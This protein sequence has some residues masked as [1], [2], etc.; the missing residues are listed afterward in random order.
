MI[1]AKVVCGAALFASTAAGAAAPAS[2]PL[3]K[4]ALPGSSQVHG[5][6]RASSSLRVEYT[7]FSKLYG[8]RAVVT[9]NSRFGLGQATR[10]TVSLSQ[11]Q[12][13][14]AGTAARG[15]EGA[16][17]IDR[18]WSDRLSTQTSASVASNGA[19]FAKRLISQNVSYKLA[20]RLVGV[21]GA[22]YSSYGN[23][24]DVT[25][26]SAGAAYYMRGATLSYRYSLLAS[27]RFGRSSGHLASVRLNDPHG[28][29]STQLWAGHGTSLYEANL[30]RTPNGRFTSFAA[31]RS[32]PIGGGIVLQA[33]VN[34]A[35]YKTAAGS[36]SGTGLVAGLSFSNWR[37]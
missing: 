25:T 31:Q 24:S 21:F 19:I 20:P 37:P 12:R 34:R 36:Y 7:D 4:G 2:S 3:A 17:A 10:F 6:G 35:W 29:G 30:P 22:K 5:F 27:Q 26:W 1:F 16:V 23:G 13:R 18:D 8:D 15:T 28:S 33:G 14:A 9:A 32:Q 11:G